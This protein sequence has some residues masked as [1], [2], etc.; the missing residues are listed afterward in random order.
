MVTEKLTFRGDSEDSGDSVDSESE[1]PSSVTRRPSTASSEFPVWTS[2][3]IPWMKS[4]TWKKLPLKVRSYGITARPADPIV[5]P[6]GSNAASASVGGTVAPAGT[7]A[8]A[9]A[10]GALEVVS[11]LAS[12]ELSRRLSNL[13]PA[14][15]ATRFSSTSR[16]AV[17][18]LA[19]T[20][21]PSTTSWW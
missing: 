21:L 20:A 8:V 19:G 10:C 6:R 15:S 18:S 17:S 14:R 13:T 5:A 3:S 1:K 9:L 16:E 2:E 12:L 4:A 11:A 7:A